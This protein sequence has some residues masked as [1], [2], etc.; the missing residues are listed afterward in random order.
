MSRY[1]RLLVTLLIATLLLTACGLSTSQPTSQD[2][3]PQPIKTEVVETVEYMDGTQGVLTPPVPDLMDLYEQLLNTDGT[4][5]GE[6]LLKLLEYASGS[7]TESTAFD[8]NNVQA[9]EITPLL[10]QA[11]YWISGP[12]A[13]T[14]EAEKI[15]PLMDRLAINADRLL[16]YAIPEGQASRPKGLASTNRQLLPDI[17]N[18]AEGVCQE[19]WDI[20]FPEPSAGES[21]T[22]CILYRQFT[23]EGIQFRIFYPIEWADGGEFLPFI[24]SAEA[25]LRQSVA[26]FLPLAFTGMPNTD[27]VFTLLPHADREGRLRPFVLAAAWMMT[28]T[29]CGVGVYPESMNISIPEFQQ[30]LAHE[31][32]HCFQFKNYTWTNT[33]SSNAIKWWQ[34]GSA[35]FFG[36]VAYPEVNAEYIFID[37]ITEN[38]KTQNIFSMDYEN[39]LFFQYLANLT[40]E[41]GVISLLASFETSRDDQAYAN[42]LEAA[43]PGFADIFHN[44]ARAYADHAITDTA[45]N[46]IPV[47][48]RTNETIFL[49]RGTRE[50]TVEPY[51]ITAYGLKLRPGRIYTLSET[52]SE[53]G[54]RDYRFAERRGQWFA[55]PGTISTTCDQKHLVLVGTN[56]S[57][58]STYKVTVE[59]DYEVIDEGDSRSC[60]RCLVGTWEMTPDSIHGFMNLVMPP[61]STYT[62]Y[63]GSMRMTFTPDGRVEGIWEDLRVYVQF[64]LGT[65]SVPAEVAYSGSSTGDWYTRDGVVYGVNSVSSFTMTMEAEGFSFSKP[66]G[67]TPGTAYTAEGPYTCTPTNL[68]FT[69]PTEPTFTREFIKVT[70]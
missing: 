2:E 62:G 57:I 32:F 6:V 26:T 68:S 39:F 52:T 20:G 29:N 1:Y 46:M 44:F 34:E 50:F 8:F 64:T 65:S 24:D 70:P 49:D 19:F 61:N 25:A 40:S 4:N 21:P 11:R 38:F 58:G 15:I 43:L 31:I 48:P 69:P 22:I 14:P 42:A 60:D 37:D 28:A 18:Q 10:Q 47:A 56:V 12:G 54:R 35:E 7:A 36:N 5:E 45:G 55:L 23:A 59:Y 3:T 27:V 33:A 53:T 63:T 30:T 41:S 9:N 66:L 51:R 67:D 16:P 13:G 17:L